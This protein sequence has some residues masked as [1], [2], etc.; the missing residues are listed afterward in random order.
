[1]PREPTRESYRYAAPQMPIGGA[2]SVFIGRL[3]SVQCVL[4]RT[5]FM[6]DSFREAGSLLNVARFGKSVDAGTTRHATAPE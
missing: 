2:F 4:R 3:L 6:K 5:R 1:M